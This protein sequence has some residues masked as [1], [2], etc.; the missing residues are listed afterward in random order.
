MDTGQNKRLRL[1]AR[2]RLRSGTDFKRIKLEG[3]RVATGCLVLN[4]VHP[5]PAGY[6]R[7]AVVAG[8][9]LGSAVVRNRARR[10]LREAFRLHQHELAAPVDLLLVARPSIVGKKCPE[11]ERDL[12]AA[13]SKAGLLKTNLA[14]G[15]S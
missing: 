1:P 13:L 8:N 5:G 3:R 7:F 10:L 14:A 4:W 15:L 12:L 9:K 6:T 11:V 2:M